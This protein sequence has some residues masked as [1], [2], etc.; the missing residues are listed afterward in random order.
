MVK[1]TDANNNVLPNFVIFDRG[2]TGHEHLLGVGLVHLPEE[3]TAG[4][5]PVPSLSRE[6]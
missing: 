1:I 6:P 2:Y 4:L 5:K 3:G